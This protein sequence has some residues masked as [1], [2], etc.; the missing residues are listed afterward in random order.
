M[1]VSNH[2]PKGI[3]HHQKINIPGALLIQDSGTILF[4]CYFCSRDCNDK[5]WTPLCHFN[6]RSYDPLTLDIIS[7]STYLKLKTETQSESLTKIED[8]EFHFFDQKT[9]SKD[10]SDL[11]VLISFGDKS[12]TILLDF[13][14]E[15][16]KQSVPAGE[17]I[18][19]GHHVFANEAIHFT[20]KEMDLFINKRIFILIIG[21]NVKESQEEIWFEFDKY[22]KQFTRSINQLVL[23]DTFS[24]DEPNEMFL[25]Q[26]SNWNQIICLKGNCFFERTKLVHHFVDGN[27][28]VPFYEG[29]G[30]MCEHYQQGFQKS[31]ASMNSDTVITLIALGEKSL[32]MTKLIVSCFSLL[33]PKTSFMIRFVKTSNNILHQISSFSKDHKLETHI[34]VMDFDSFL[35][36]E[37]INKIPFST[38]TYLI[39]SSFEHWYQFPNRPNSSLFLFNQPIKSLFVLNWLLDSKDCSH[40]PRNIFTIPFYHPVNRLLKRLIKYNDAN[41]FKS[42][43]VTGFKK[44]SLEILLDSFGCINYN[45]DQDFTH[46]PSKNTIINL[47]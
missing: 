46:L 10:T 15:I 22:S 11:F 41:S 1:I 35:K 44:Q 47:V 30:F 2:C 23:I 21:C 14:T 3:K 39:Q 6:I 38:V 7:K 5:Q 9:D 26:N 29:F 18:K 28:N 33:K 31:I 25:N 27:K 19:I 8:Q 45:V 17:I 4:Q 37:I 32:E 43:K 13:Y 24:N 40:V 12:T 20:P 36:P 42:L 16:I 34:F